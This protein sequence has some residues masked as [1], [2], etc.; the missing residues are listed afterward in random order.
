MTDDTTPTAPLAPLSQRLGPIAA[1]VPPAHPGI[2]EWRPSTIDDVDALTELFRASDLV[3]HPS[4]TTPREEIEESFTVSWTDPERNTLVGFDAAGRLI[5]SAAVMVHPSRDAQVHMY[6]SGRVHPEA[7][8][9]G[10]GREVMRWEHERALEALAELDL[11]LPAAIFVYAD[12]GDVGAQ[13]LATRRGLVAERWFTTM[14]RDLSIEIPEV[15]ASGDAVVRAYEPALKEATRLARNDAFRDH[16]GSLETP[17][18]RWDTFV[19]GPFLRPDLS[20]VAVEGDRVVALALGSVNE[21]DW[22]TQGYSSVY[23]DLIGVTRDRRGRRLAPAVIVALLLAARDAGLEK[24]VLDVDTESPTGA[25]N[26]YGRLGFE[27][28][29]RSVALVRRY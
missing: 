6:L 5:A 26:L 1:P 2:A 25:N 9:R 22:A 8:G 10:I 13:H 16:W 11:A 18:E 27:A 4:W 23:I 19:E 7:R 3:D 21:E 20:R 14:V 29:E 15:E 24:A 12:E 17:P 28:T